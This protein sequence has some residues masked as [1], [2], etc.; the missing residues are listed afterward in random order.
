MEE[1]EQLKKRLESDKYFFKLDRSFNPYS[2]TY[3]NTNENLKGYIKNLY[4]K[5]VL[6]VSS[7]GDQLLNILGSGSNDIDTFD[8]NRYSPFVQNLKL[9]SVKYLDN[10]SSFNFLNRLNKQIYLLFND[11]LPNDEKEF[12]D[13]LFKYNLEDV[14]DK[15]FYYSL[16]NNNLNNNYF[17]FKVLNRI[18]NNIDKIK[19]N[20]YNCDIYDL[21]KYIDKKYDVIYLSNISHYAR[22][23]DMFLNYIN[24]LRQYLNYNGKIYYGY[25]YG[26]CIYESMTAIK[27]INS[28]FDVRFDK[29]KYR[30][31][32]NHT[33]VINIDCAEY[34]NK[35]DSV[36][37]LRK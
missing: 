32:L 22:D 31:I 2:R 26:K 23:I 6:T 21:Y 33:E 28:N 34:R 3:Y 29:Y 20:H 30:D 27:N 17:N 36:L 25:L 1:V 9:Y 16:D 10:I 18:R 19:H 12:F 35:K 11:Y 14:Y 5:K 13:Y 8:I 7:S 37:V 4:G 15:F 24:Y